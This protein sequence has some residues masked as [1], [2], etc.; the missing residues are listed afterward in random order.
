MARGAGCA[1]TSNHVRRSSTR[2]RQPCHARA[3]TL[4]RM[5][6]LSALGF[7]SSIWVQRAYGTVGTK[8][9][10]VPRLLGGARC[11][12]GRRGNM[13]WFD[14]ARSSAGVFPTTRLLQGRWVRR[15]RTSHLRSL[16]LRWH[17][18]EDDEDLAC[19]DAGSG[20]H[21]LDAPYLARQRC[22][23]KSA[24]T[25]TYGDRAPFWFGRGRRSREERIKTM[26]TR[27]LP[28]FGPH[29]CVKP[30]CCF[31]VLYCVLA[32]ERVVLQYT[33]AAGETEREWLP[34]PL[35]LRMGPPIICARGYPQVAT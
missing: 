31:V 35:P 16:L 28:S 18:D 9:L 19:A 1:R 21:N 32:Q 10:L 15:G 3:S 12:F 6:A 14:D 22:Q 4:V 5:L 8:T 25:N 7:A 33:R 27:G 17:V 11:K 13:N 24:S 34:S 20:S 23:G 26:H 2:S 30:Y 29:G